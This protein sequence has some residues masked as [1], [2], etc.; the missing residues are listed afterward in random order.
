MYIQ[1]LDIKDIRSFKNAKI[2]FSENINVIIGHNNSGKSTLLKCIQKLQNSQQNIQ[3][4]DI[5]KTTYRG[6]IAIELC[7]QSGSQIFYKYTHGSTSISTFSK[8]PLRVLFDIDTSSE[9]HSFAKATNNTFIKKNNTDYEIITYDSGLSPVR[10]FDGLHNSE[11]KNNHIYP[12]F[13]KRKMQFYS[14][15]NDIN[16]TFSVDEDLRN[17]PA[18]IK[19]LSNGSHPAHDEFVQYCEKILGFKIGDVP[20]DNNQ[21]K[22]GIYTTDKDIVYLESMGEGVANILGLLAILL[23]EDNKVFLIEEL[24]NDIH[25]QSLKYLLELIANKSTNNQFIISTHSN[26]VLKY[27]ASVEN[28]KVFYTSLDIVREGRTKIPTSTVEEIE[29][30]PEKRLEILERLGYELYD[31]DLYSAYIILEESS[32]E[33]V[34]KELLIPSFVPELLNKIKTISAGG[35]TN[36]ETR[37]DDFLRLFVYIHTNSIYNKKAWVIADGDAPGIEHINKLKE[38]FTTW[39]S[40]HF[41]NFTKDNFE[42]YYPEP[43]LSKYK[44]IEKIQSKDE[45]R[46]AKA[47]LTKEVV[48][49]IRNNREQATKEFRKSAKDVIDVLQSIAEKLKQTA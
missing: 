39:D 27:L 20:G 1:Q 41:I 48:E 49:H 5:R 10:V 37:F 23:T 9:R 8:E 35:V 13:S 17:L 2:E 7:V 16:A 22:L 26:I 12:F 42:E 11:D 14:S 21:T 24:E 46:K 38:K 30:T 43:F 33:Q 45:R 34:I 28:S 19:K 32:A 29:N 47:E 15:S 6:F 18:K 44:E 25:P 40:E 31:F 4:Y 3:P 36:L